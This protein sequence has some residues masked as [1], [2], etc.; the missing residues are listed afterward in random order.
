GCRGRD[1]SAP[2]YLGD[3]QGKADPGPDRGVHS[4]RVARRRLAP[5][6]ALIALGPLALPERRAQ[7]GSRAGA[8][9]ADPRPP[10]QGTQPDRP[11]PPPAAL[12]SG[13]QQRAP[14]LPAVGLRGGAPPSSPPALT[15]LPGARAL[16]AIHS[17]ELPQRDDLCGAFCASLALRAAGVEDHAAEP[18]DQDAVALAAGSIVSAFQVGH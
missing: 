5:G 12:P 2:V 11:R 15:P 6:V 18:L 3:P 7:D 16:L 10:A 17:R 1:R 8:L 4:G 9:S 13:A 14:G